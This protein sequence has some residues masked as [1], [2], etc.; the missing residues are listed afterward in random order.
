MKPPFSSHRE[1]LTG[2]RARICQ[3]WKELSTWFVRLSMVRLVGNNI[4]LIRERHTTWHTYPL[5]EPKIS[6][7]IR[8]NPHHANSGASACSPCASNCHANLCLPAAANRSTG[9][10]AAFC[11][12]RESS[13]FMNCSMSTLYAPKGSDKRD[14]D[15]EF[16]RDTGDSLRTKRL[17]YP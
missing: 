1:K 8:H 6:D 12:S 16:C 10:H 14:K 2:T 7:V 15:G 3:F 13:P 5:G 9:P 11:Y 17:A 4:Q